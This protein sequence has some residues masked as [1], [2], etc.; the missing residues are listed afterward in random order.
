MNLTIDEINILSEDELD[1]VCGGAFVNPSDFWVSRTPGDRFR[2]FTWR[3]NK[4]KH[5]GKFKKWTKTRKC[6]SIRAGAGGDGIDGD[7]GNEGNEGNEG[8]EGNEGNERNE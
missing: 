6:F 3:P 4:C 5:T 2:S 7:E 8:D 1:E